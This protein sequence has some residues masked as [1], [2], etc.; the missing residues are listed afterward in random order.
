MIRKTIA[1][2]CAV[3]MMASWASAQPPRFRWQ[4]GQV[5][6]YRTEHNTVASYVMGDNTS[7]TKTRVQSIKRWQVMGV[8]DGG[9]ATLQMSIQ[10]LVFEMVRPDGKSEMFDSAHPENSP[11]EV[12]KAFAYIGQP[13]LLLRV[14]GQGKVVEV[15]Q[16]EVGHGSMAKFESEP[17]FKLLL[18]AEAL[19]TDLAWERAY[20]IT[21]EPPQG[22]GEKYDAVQRY[23]CKSLVENVA[24]MALTTEVKNPPAATEDQIP[25]WQMQPEGE[26]VFDASNGRLL[27]ATLRI[28]K[29][30]KAESG[31][32]RFQSVYTEQYEGDR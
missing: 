18:P 12:R 20:Q 4:N 21:L 22:T 7:E 13:L 6:V 15:K 19:K 8:E 2:L 25:V 26:L 28:D 3:V 23:L 30:A 5:L 27:K 14:D 24:T 9:V 17:P 32:T 16:A 10:A 29:E 11:E 31:S 1:A